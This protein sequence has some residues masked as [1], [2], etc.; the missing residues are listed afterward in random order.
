MCLEAGQLFCTPPSHLF[1]RPFAI[2][3]DAREHRWPEFTLT[4][5]GKR[6]GVGETEQQ[7]DKSMI[8][9][10]ELFLETLAWWTADEW[11]MLWWMS[12]GQRE[13]PE[14]SIVLHWPVK[15][16]IIP[17]SH[18]W[19]SFFPTGAASQYWAVTISLPQ[20]WTRVLIQSQPCTEIYHT[21]V[22]C[23]SRSLQ[24]CWLRYRLQFNG[25]SVNT[26]PFHLIPKLQKNNASKSWRSFESTSTPLLGGFISVTNKQK[27]APSLS[28]KQEKERT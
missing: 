12:G 3:I 20:N 9:N 26:L 10:S 11:W 4:G 7:P 19:H 21:V 14:R 13:P 24:A 1:G 5:E 2:L 25:I 6:N 17:R 16:S 18:L 15:N 8:H 22:S 28:M 27:V 23:F